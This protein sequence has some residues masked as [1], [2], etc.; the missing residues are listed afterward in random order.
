[1]IPLIL[2]AAVLLYLTSDSAAERIRLLVEA[3]AAQASGRLVSV[4]KVTLDLLP[5]TLELHGVEV[6]G[7]QVDRPPFL[8]AEAVGVQFGLRGLFWRRAVRLERLWVD[9]PQVALTIDEEG[10]IDLPRPRTGGGGGSLEIEI[11]NLVIA[12]GEL[13][14]DDLRLPVDLDASEVSGTVAGAGSDLRLIGHLD[15]QRIEV[16]LPGARPYT[17]AGSIALALEPRKGLEITAGRFRG[18]GEVV[19]IQGVVGWEKGPAREAREAA[20]GTESTEGTAA[21]GLTVHLTIEARG[22]TELATRLGYLDGQAAG[23]YS[24]NGRYDRVDG[25]WELTGLAHASR[26]SLAG[27]Q[28]RDVVTQLRLVKTALH[29]ELEEA[30]WYGGTVRGEG[31]V[32]LAAPDSAQGRR[33]PLTLDLQ[34]DGV[35][36]KELLRQRGVEGAMLAGLAGRLTGKAA[37]RCDLSEALAGQGWIEVDLEPEPDREGAGLAVAGH[38]GR[39]RAAPLP[40]AGDALFSIAGGVVSSGGGIILRA[41]ED[42]LVIDRLAVDVARRAGQLDFSLA[43]SALGRWTALVSAAGA[44]GPQSDS[45]PSFLPAT[46]VGTVVGELSFE[47]LY[48]DLDARLDLSAVAL[49]P[50]EEGEPIAV[51]SL[52]GSLSVSPRGVSPLR[53]EATRGRGAM[54]MAGTIPFE[55]PSPVDR[56][57]ADSPAAESPEIPLALTFDAAAWPSEELIAML[58][59]ELPLSGP[60][61]GQ[62][63]LGGSAE[64][65]HGAGRLQVTPARWSGVELEA[66]GAQLALDPGQ[67][68]VREL[69]AKMAAGTAQ[70]QGTLGL[71][72]E[73]PLAFTARVE[74]LDL[75]Q[76]PLATMLKSSLSGNLIGSATLG[77]TLAQPSG[78]LSGRIENLGFVGEELGSG[79]FEAGWDGERIDLKANLGEL[80]TLAGGGPFDGAAGDLRL[81]V[82]STQLG[83][84]ARL[85]M[86]ESG[87]EVSG[88]F[89]GTLSVNGALT[90]PDLAL[91][92]DS[93]H[94]GFAGHRLSALEPATAH[95]DGDRLVID[96]LYLGDDG[97]EAEF[98]LHGALSPGEGDLDLQL[99]AQL[100]AQW[101][102][103]ILPEARLRGVISALGRVGGSLRQPA[104][105]GQADLSAGQL[106]L[107]GFPHAF[108]D[109]SAVVLA[110]PDRIKLDHLTATVAGGALRAEGTLFTDGLAVND[111][112]FQAKTEGF[113]LLYPEGWLLAGDALLTLVPEEGG[114]LVQGSVDLDRADYLRDLRVGAVQLLQGMLRR[115]RLEAGSVDPTLAQTRLNVLLRVPDGLRIDNNVAD[116]RGSAELTVRGDLARPVVLGTVELEPG[117][118]LLYSDT[119]YQV[120]RG[121]MTFSSSTRINPQI[122]LVARSKVRDYDVTLNLSGSL[123]RL[124]VNLA[125][126]PPLPDLEVLSLLTTGETLTRGIA[127]GND[128]PGSTLGSS[129]QVARGILVGQAASVVSSRVKKLFGF[130]TF[131]IDPLSA[132]GDSGSTA[133]VTFGKQL[134]KDLFVTYSNDPSSNR[135]NIVKVE[136]QALPGL[137]IEVTSVDQLTFSQS[138]N[139]ALAVDLRWQKRY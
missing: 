71:E 74:G 115:Q 41:G 135:D 14:F 138:D 70:A 99:Q 65:V 129:G 136:W 78:Q 80:I 122:D 130:D 62:W 116:L 8:Q 90:S 132:A 7:A 30:G 17:A 54:L 97:E 95:L 5:P 36:L 126:D 19:D 47:K 137:V 26:L 85:A 89:A 104:L 79:R 56:S 2:V 83:A 112:R 40:L 119:R 57:A 108:D 55:P 125:S 107:S 15:V 134:S 9:R 32:D 69:T 3:Q 33:R 35:H 53:L 29:V 38:E 114:R 61:S 131:R 118:E 34:F 63:I 59:L 111:Y 88:D 86:G 42:E 50:F 102:E 93:L 16:L 106:I 72:G 117:G 94:I 6:A 13:V 92:L 73:Q 1:M 11:G 46:G 24:F 81:D 100:P 103:L 77:G 25:K 4:D 91:S 37:Y 120:D 22:D 31:L 113:R 45:E 139:G 52:T 87:H 84:M 124:Q 44:D 20:A 39:T 110:Y 133:R 66:V 12:S 51:D 43:T 127:F 67:L 105:D 109:A 128:E 98:F 68:A 23:G 18:P 27:E 82:A 76:E 64:A 28:L 10:Q 121:L 58:G 60:L 21:S 96:S 49:R 101:L 75:A 123:N 48:Y